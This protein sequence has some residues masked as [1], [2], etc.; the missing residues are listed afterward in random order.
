MTAVI[1]RKNFLILE[2]RALATGKRSQLTPEEW[3]YL[4]GEVDEDDLIGPQ[5]EIFAGFEK[6]IRVLNPEL[7]M[8]VVAL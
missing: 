2:G 5:I 6:Q 4:R 7:K 3:L 8:D 1:Q